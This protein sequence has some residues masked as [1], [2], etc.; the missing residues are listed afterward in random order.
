MYIYMCIYG[1]GGCSIMYVGRCVH[2]LVVVLLLMSVGCCVHILGGGGIA[3]VCGVTVL[4]AY[5][6]CWGGGGSIVCICGCWSSWWCVHM[7][8]GVGGG[9]SI[10]YISYVGGEGGGVVCICGVFAGGGVVCKY[11]VQ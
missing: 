8:G 2:I 10:V 3:C 11:N 5:V 9:G 4:C 7:W 1:G 6:G